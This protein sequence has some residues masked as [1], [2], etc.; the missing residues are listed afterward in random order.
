MPPFRID[1]QN[2]IP[3]YAQLEQAIR[4]AAISGMLAIGERLPTVR[5]LAVELRVNANTVAK[6]YASLESEGMLETKRGVGTFLANAGKPPSKRERTKLMED[7]TNS[8]L[9]DAQR[10]GFTIAELIENL[11]SRQSK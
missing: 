3:L 11:K 8:V 2:P 9:A 6:V 10:A 1:Q 7:F 5:E 4:A